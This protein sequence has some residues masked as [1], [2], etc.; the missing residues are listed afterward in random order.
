M[1]LQTFVSTNQRAQIDNVIT[2]LINIFLRGRKSYFQTV[3]LQF[4]FGTGVVEKN[5]NK[6]GLLVV[7]KLI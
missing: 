7:L 2:K 6:V 1:K 5:A 4:F 3:P